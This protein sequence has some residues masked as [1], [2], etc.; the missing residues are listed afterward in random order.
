MLTIRVIAGGK[1]YVGNHLVHS[2]YYDEHQEVEGEWWG[3]AAKELELEG[4]VETEQVESLRVGH[5][6]QTGEKIRQ[7][8]DKDSRAMF[9]LTWS[10]PKSV[11]IVAKLGPDERLEAAHNHAVKEA[12]VEAEKLAATRVRGQGRNSDRVTQNLVVALY[13]HDTSRKCDPQ[14]HTH[15]V[16]FNVTKDREEGRWKALQPRPIFDDLQYLTEVY[17]NALAREV[18][19]LGYEIETTLDESGKNLGFEIAGIGKELRDKFSRRSQDRDEAIRAFELEKGRPAT[20]RE[21]AVLVRATR[22]DKLYSITTAALREQ[23][24]GRLNEAERNEIRSVLHDAETRRFEERIHGKVT[25]SP[26]FVAETT[27]AY[28]YALQHLFERLTVASDRAIY[29]EALAF[30]RGQVNVEVLQSLLDASAVTGE[31]IHS[32]GKYAS[33]KSLLEEA[34]MIEN[35]DRGIG[36]YG[37]LGTDEAMTTLKVSPDQ[38]RAILGV[39]DSRDRVV[40]IQG[41]AGTGK[42]STLQTI[43]QGIRESGKEVTALAPTAAAVSVLQKDGFKAM[44]IDKF[45]NQAW[46]APKS[47]KERVVFVDEAGMVGN[48][49][50]AQLLDLTESLDTRV[51][52][53]G[54]TR[55]LRSV[56]AGDSFRILQKESRMSTHRLTS[57]FRQSGAYKVAIAAL[58]DDPTVGFQKLSKMKAIHEHEEKDMYSAAAAEVV[59]QMSLPNAKGEARSTLA[60]SPTWDGVRKLTEAIRSRLQEEKK[61][62]WSVP[63]KTLR[64]RKLTEAQRQNMANYRRGD[65]VIFQKDIK[66]AKRGEIFKVSLNLGSRVVL[67]QGK[68][69][70]T[71][72]KKQAKAMNVYE[73][74]RTWVARGDRLLLQRNLT[75]QREGLFK[76]PA[77]M[78]RSPVVAAVKSLM[79]STD[80]FSPKSESKLK[81]GLFTTQERFANGEIVTVRTHDHKGR[82][83]LTDGRVLPNDYM[84]YTHGWAVTAHASQGK[85]VDSVIVAGNRMTRETFYVAASRGRESVSIFTSDKE[86]LAKSVSVDSTRLSAHELKQAAM[87]TEAQ[88]HSAKQSVRSV[89]MNKES[90]GISRSR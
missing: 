25:S 13:Q 29:R 31:L 19:K 49:K 81:V 20:K 42:T 30:G 37:K 82:I 40:G 21:I 53:V 8:V 58:R 87:K 46:N 84:T 90:M 85:T 26:E 54:D 32:D 11:S 65:Y 59:R 51:V 48:H 38:I 69:V 68:R 79:K 10:A 23:Q 80:P 39:L 70:M 7:R 74:T 45:M 5:N 34:R 50:M 86:G 78:H 60:V 83:V 2:D 56:D 89:G 67:T 63:H 9:D 57:I 72:T 52:L 24:R 43:T 62:D 15:A 18:T 75:V 55:Q 28:K 76:A 41:A 61:I 33:R 88:E 17:R 6:P 16:V 66:N 1:T 77:F 47:A 44:T 14:L 27:A 64:D 36:M 22:E 4:K 3:I 71:V 73:K 12:M 35:V